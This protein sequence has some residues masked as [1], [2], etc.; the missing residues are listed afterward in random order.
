MRAFGVMAWEVRI[1][2]HRVVLF[3]HSRQVFAGRPQPLGP[4]GTA[5]VRS[6]KS[7]PRLP[8]PIHHEVSDLVWRVVES[9]WYG[10]AVGEVVTLLEAELTR[11]S[12]SGA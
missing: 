10:V 8:R 2:V 9:C 5:P 11:I 4:D 6:M 1:S 7:G 12:A 3:A